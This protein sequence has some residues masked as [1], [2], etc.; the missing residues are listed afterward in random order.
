MEII[1]HRLGPDGPIHPADDEVGRLALIP[2]VAFY[3]PYVA[4]EGF[5]LGVCYYPEHWDEAR[6]RKAPQGSGRSDWA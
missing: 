5:A 2:F 4:F 1:R 6:R 3:V